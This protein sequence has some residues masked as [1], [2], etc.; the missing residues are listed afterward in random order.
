MTPNPPIQSYPDGTIVATGQ[1][2]EVYRLLMLKHRMILEVNHPT[3]RF[4]ISTG[5]IIR[6]ILTEHGIQNLPRQ[7]A[8]LLE[9]YT[10]WLDP[11][12]AT[13]T[14]DPA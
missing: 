4:R 8:K 7:K 12:L 5:P 14:S 1:G 6:Q 2:V 3:M 10:E 11:Y 13:L 9:V